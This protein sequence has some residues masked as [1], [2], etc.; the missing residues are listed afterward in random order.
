MSNQKQPPKP[1]DGP[2]VSFQADAKVSDIFFCQDGEYFGLVMV[3]GW[4]PDPS[5]DS[6]YL[7]FLD[8]VRGCFDEPD[9]TAK[10]SLSPLPAVYLYPSKFIH[11]T[12]ATFAPPEKR[13]STKDITDSHSEFQRT[14][15]SLVQEASKLSNWPKD[16]IQLTVRSTQ[17]GSKAG[18]LLWDDTSGSIAKIRDCIRE[19]AARHYLNIWGIPDIIHSTFLRFCQVPQTDGHTVQ[20]RFQSKVI[21]QVHNVFQQPLTT[22]TVKLV[23]ESTPYMHIPDD[24]R[25]VVHVWQLGDGSS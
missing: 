10:N 2:A 1:Q 17:L 24:D 18:I 3:A 20:N 13:G 15:L 19:T 25:H 5:I 7:K 4:P 11:V 21:P 16:P 22:N 9:L 8:L 23:I 12:I 6:P 14:Y